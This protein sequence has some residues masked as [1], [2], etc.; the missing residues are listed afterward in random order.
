MH[1]AEGIGDERVAPEIEAALGRTFVAHAVHRDDEH[2]VGDRVRALDGLPGGELRRAVL[3]F[4]SRV[5]ADRGRVEQDFG[6]VQR[7]EARGLGVPLIPADQGADGGLRRGERD[8]AEIAGREVVLLVEQR[9]VRD[10]HLAVQADLGAVRAVDDDAVVIHAGGAALEDRRHHGHA[11][12]LGHLSDRLRCW[13]RD[14]LGEIEQRSVF[15]LAEVLRGEELLQADDAST[16]LGGVANE[17]DRLFDVR[18][19]VQRDRGLDQ[20][21]FHRPCFHGGGNLVRAAPAGHAGARHRPV[22]G[23]NART[24]T[25]QRRAS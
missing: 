14:R 15:D 10:V 24:S 8:E 22:T 17:V 11:A 21:D 9:I 16:L 7:G 3:S 25:R 2:A 1:D 5:P 20:P 19:L 6:T 12:L 23:R 18:C 13:A 4:F